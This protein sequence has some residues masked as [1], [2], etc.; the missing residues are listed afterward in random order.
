MI[1]DMIDEH[2]RE[3]FRATVWDYYRD[4]GRHDL[5]WRLPD[6]G[7][8]DAYKVMVSELMLQQTQAKRVI[9]KYYEF[10]EW[11]PDIRALA[12]APL[13]DILG[14]WSGL[15]YNRRAKFL[16]QAAG[17]IV[18]DYD[19]QFPRLPGELAKL[20]GIGP[21]TAGAITAYAYNQPTVFIE[22]NIRTVFI[23]HFFHD[24]TDIPDQAIVPLI[25]RTLDRE[26]PREW[27]YAL[28]DY[29]AHLKQTVGNL[30]RH[31]KSYARQS[32]FQ[33]SRRQIRGQVIRLLSGR[34]YEVR[35]LEEHIPDQ[36]LTIILQELV[37]E[38]LIRRRGS[39][40]SL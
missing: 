15:G 19:G 26:N 34:S 38:G 7:G 24:Q 36:R 27:Y 21:N 25:A 18:R 16:R 37:A 3:L 9:P 10:L 35:E 12:E 14:V 20:P 40:Y 13:G 33:G 2:A 39:A 4:H 8:F 5:P 30:S 28:T 29:G 32:E 1:N 11:F 23:H 17:L 31:S 6:S 22:T